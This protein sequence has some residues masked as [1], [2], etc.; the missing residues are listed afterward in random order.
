MYVY[1]RSLCLSAHNTKQLLLENKH[2]FFVFLIGL[3][4]LVILPPYQLFA[5][6]AGDVANDMPSS[7]HATLVLFAQCDIYDVAEQIGFAVR[8]TEILDAIKKADSQP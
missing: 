2:P 3:K 5:L 1:H 8:P 7:C 6:A 4:C